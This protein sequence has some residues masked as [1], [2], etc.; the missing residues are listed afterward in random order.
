[1]NINYPVGPY[2]G[3][4]YVPELN[5]GRDE[6]LALIDEFLPIYEK[7]P[8]NN[9]GGIT[10][11][12]SLA[13][14]YF[15]KRI[16]PSLIIESGV[17]RGFSTWVIDQI[18]QDKKHIACD[19]V[20]MMPIKFESV[21]WP[22]MVE[23][24]CADYSC[25]LTSVDEPHRVV[26]FFDDHQN[27]VPRLIQSIRH[28]FLWTIWDDNYPVKDDHFSFESD[29]ATEGLL[30]SW[31]PLVKDYILFPPAVKGSDPSC[32]IDPVFEALPPSLKH[33]EGTNEL[34]YSYMTFVETHPRNV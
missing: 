16:D 5:P 29:F 2:E 21:Y 24:I 17:W 14:Y 15:M 31:I 22:D 1:M 8:F 32:P 26:T 10:F 33:F 23:K 28:G 7:R 19:P 4:D 30:P 18:H 12:S 25:L 11:W 3:V 27:Y 34:A 20:F 13:L 9:T 6:I